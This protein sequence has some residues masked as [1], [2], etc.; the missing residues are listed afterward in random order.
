MTRIGIIG[1]GAAARHIHLPAYRRLGARLELVGGADPDFSARTRAEQLGVRATF[2]TPISMLEAGRPDIVA[3][4]SPPA[5][6]R[7]HALLALAAGCHVF[8]EK[9]LATD[10][11]EAD[12]IIAAAAAAGRQVV[13][14]NQFPAMRIH[15]AAHAL[16]GGP[17][18]GS[19][20]YLHAWHTMRPSDRTEAGWRGQLDRRLGLEFGVHVFDLVRFFFGTTPVRI[21]AHMPRPDPSISWDAINAV[22]FD[23]AD[24]RAASCLLDRLS[25]GPER[26]LDLRL[27]GELAAIHTSIG[28][29]V[30]LS[31]GLRTRTRRPFVDWQLAG[32]GRAVLQRGDD[33][34]LIGRD[35]TNPFA[36]ATARHLGAFLDAL[37]DGST[38]PARAADNRETL[39]LV[40][41]AYDSA[42]MGTPVEMAPYLRAGT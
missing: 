12:A 24:G 35:G 18:F 17:E 27:D 32:G 36:S 29:R 2:D 25:Q 34:R 3:V 37:E 20:L 19:L 5:L 26:Y 6:H 16:I 42:R 9:P 13:V 33:E 11:A 28:G 8:L 1:L 31:A 14:N 7:E 40:L 10:L 22:T 30:R 38:P 41:A 39:A 21:S 15:A 23:F 4:C